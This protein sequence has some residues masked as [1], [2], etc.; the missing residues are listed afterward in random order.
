MNNNPF[1]VPENYF[2]SLPNKIEERIKKSKENTT[3]VYFLETAKPYIAVAASIAIILSVWYFVSNN[4]SQSV[5]GLAVAQE[6]WQNI[7]TDSLNVRENEVMDYLLAENQLNTENDEI[8][9]ENITDEAIIEYLGESNID[10][11]GE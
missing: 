9:S 8:N 4:N 7:D 10:I 2:D 6:T 3:K 1:K 5:S 11:S